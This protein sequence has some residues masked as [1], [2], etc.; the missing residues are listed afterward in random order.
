[1]IKRIIE[2]IRI[3]R[4]P[5]PFY[6]SLLSDWGKSDVYGPWTTPEDMKKGRFK[7]YYLLSG[8]GEPK[9]E[10]VPPDYKEK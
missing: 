7:S 9:M 4:K 8:P 5:N 6:L 10:I 1:M 2:S 3:N